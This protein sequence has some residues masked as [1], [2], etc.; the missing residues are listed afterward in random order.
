MNGAGAIVNPITG[1]FKEVFPARAV[2]IYAA[3]V[4]GDYREEVIIVDER[5]YVRVLWNAQ[6]NANPPKARYWTQQH[7]R[8]QKQNWNYYSP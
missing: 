3:D 1:E 2:R 6:P 5:G 7:Y 8:R 4:L